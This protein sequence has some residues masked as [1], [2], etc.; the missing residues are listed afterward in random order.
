M[1]LNDEI[2]PAIFLTEESKKNIFDSLDRL[3]DYLRS[4]GSIDFTITYRHEL[5]SSLNVRMLEV[6]SFAQNLKSGLDIQVYLG[7]RAGSASCSGAIWDDWQRTADQAL[8]FASLAQED[9]YLS[10]PPTELFSN[11]II[12]CQLYQPEVLPSQKMLDLALELERSSLNFSEKIKNSDGASVDASYDFIWYLNS[13]GLR[14]MIP[15]S[16]YGYAVSVLAQDGDSVEADSA[17]EYARAWDLLSN[18]EEIG[19][20]A[21]SRAISRLNPQPV[22]SGYYPVIFSPRC[23]ASLLGHLFA[24]LTG[25]SQYMKATM[26]LDALG[27][28]ILPN[29]MNISDNPH[30][31]RGQKS[32]PLDDDGLPTY[33]HLFV[34]NG[35]IKEYILSYYSAKRLGLKPNHLSGGLM[36]TN[37]TT[38]I[39]DLQALLNLYPKIILIDQLSGTG[40]NIVNGDYSRGI[41]GFYVENG[42]II[43]A[44][45][46]TTVAGN[47]KEMFMNIEFHAKDAEKNRSIQAGSF[48]IHGMMTA[49][50]E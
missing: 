16:S 33:P 22:V 7:H 34:Q 23:S 45:K 30:L 43:H 47:L 6:E 29:W 9:P 37:L 19:K 27:K 10:L 50:S 35:V 20:K 5:S 28:Q 32:S 44:V 25:R 48:M 31:A 40:V 14:V 49:G 11:H 17:Y 8:I 39:S 18:P 46:E 1:S 24:S 4:K 15:A 3:S 38:N 41:D 13:K 2:M 42:Q 26:N 21:A 36:N 12:D